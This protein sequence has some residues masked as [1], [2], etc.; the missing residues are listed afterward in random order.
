MWSCSCSHAF[1]YTIDGSSTV[2]FICELLNNLMTLSNTELR[3]VVNKCH[4]FDR[5]SQNGPIKPP[6]KPAKQER[7]QPRQQ[8]QDIARLP[9]TTDQWMAGLFATHHTGGAYIAGDNWWTNTVPTLTIRWLIQY[10]FQLDTFKL[11]DA[12]ITEII[13]TVKNAYERGQ[14]C[15]SYDKSAFPLRT[16]KSTISY[17]I[18]WYRYWYDKAQIPLSTFVPVL[19]V[20]GT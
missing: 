14:L 7:Q 2:P 13:M 3:D 12:V 8:K 15:R 1:S 17:I 10:G 16:I 11:N 5:V 4:S 20:Y 6:S 9:E 18:M 19:A